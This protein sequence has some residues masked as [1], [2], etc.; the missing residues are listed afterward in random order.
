MQPAPQPSSFPAHLPPSAATRLARAASLFPAL[1]DLKRMRRAGAQGSLAEQAFLEGWSLLTAGAEPYQAA[2]LLL[3]R[4]L[5][6][7]QFA[8]LR[9][10]ELEEVLDQERAAA[11]EAAAL[12]K[13]V[14]GSF[15]DHPLLGEAGKPVVTTGDVPA[16]AALLAEQPRAGATHPTEG[17]LFLYPPE[18]HA[19]HCW[20][21]AIYAI[22]LAP[23]FGADI[24]TVYLA[25]M[26]HHLHNAY[27]PDGGF[28]GEM[29]LEPHLQAVMQGFRKKAL[30]ELP[31]SLADELNEAHDIISASAA[32][33]AMAFHAADVLDRV[34]DV[35]WRAQAAG[36]T[37]DIATKTYG[38]V[39]E[40]P[41]K[42]YHET[43]L[44]A[45]KID[46]C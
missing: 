4:A 27:L 41:H 10:E 40:G 23:S 44:T 45:A 12:A 39:H 22:L 21:V 3:R 43:V 28:A 29:L 30:A 5:L 19:E 18:S 26:G 35:R 31:V 32:P 46:P 11:I 14:E 25:A 36:F 34:L 24:G 13:S 1:Q 8:G 17:R 16:F 9:R 37:L 33:E 20:G 2:Q 6:D 15:E 7:N 42:D 38:L